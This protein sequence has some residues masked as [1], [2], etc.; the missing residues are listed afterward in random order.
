MENYSEDYPQEIERIQ[1]RF[2]ELW[3]KCSEKTASPEE[4]AEMLQMQIDY[5]TK[6]ET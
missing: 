6:D 2:S 1:N 4:Q 5:W 3:D